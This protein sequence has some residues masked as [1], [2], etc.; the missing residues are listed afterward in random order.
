MYY[1]FPWHRALIQPR[2]DKNLLPYSSCDVYASQI[3]FLSACTTHFILHEQRN[4][5][6]AW[7]ILPL[8]R[9]DIS[10]G[11]NLGHCVQLPLE[12]MPPYWD[13]IAQNFYL[14]RHFFLKKNQKLYLGYFGIDF[15]EMFR[16]C[17]SFIDG[18]LTLNWWP[19]SSICQA[20]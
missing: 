9:G 19:F 3:T 15:S 18:G 17:P 8:F 7:P 20:V 14:V 13:W 16:I 4:R 2:G 5:P 6:L 1:L 11:E 10:D 12:P